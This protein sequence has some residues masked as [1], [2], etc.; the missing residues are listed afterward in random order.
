MIDH[1]Q[2]IFRGGSH[3][4]FSLRT[5]DEGILYLAGEWCGLLNYPEDITLS[6]QINSS[7]SIIMARTRKVASALELQHKLLPMQQKAIA[8][9]IEAGRETEEIT[10]WICN[11]AKELGMEDPTPTVHNSQLYIGGVLR[12]LR[13]Q[14]DAAAKMGYSSLPNAL[15][16][17]RMVTTRITHDEDMLPDELRKVPNI[18]LT[19]KPQGKRN[20][21]FAPLTVSTAL[22]RHR[23]MTPL[24]VEV[25]QLTGQDE[26]LKEQVIYDFLRMSADD[27]EK[28]LYRHIHELEVVP[29]EEEFEE[30]ARPDPS[31]SELSK[32]VDAVS[33]FDYGVGGSL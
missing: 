29:L 17:L 6:P 8:A 30:I 9:M 4:G 27:F 28:E 26:E 7:T 25:W 19:G 15:K 23:V 18:W 14:T 22:R 32:C 31:V 33:R 1:H 3:I 5:I 24:I 11:T 12:T 10:L 20:K 13:A 16:A 2:N 21:G